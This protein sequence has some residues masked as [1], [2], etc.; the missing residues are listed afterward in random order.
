MGSTRHRNLPAIYIP[1]VFHSTNARGSRRKLRG[2]R[3]F[4]KIRVHCQYL[5]TCCA[6]SKIRCATATHLFCL[7]SST[8]KGV[9]KN[10]RFDVLPEYTLLSY[11]NTP[12]CVPK[13]KLKLCFMLVLNLTHFQVCISERCV[14]SH[15]WMCNKAQL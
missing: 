2:P 14:L 15:I 3:M 12:W 5:K 4:I 6:C 10:T 11:P 8:L 7:Q 13:G 9:Y 1:M